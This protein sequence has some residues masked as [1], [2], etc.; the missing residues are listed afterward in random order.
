MGVPSARPD[1]VYMTAPTCPP[2]DGPCGIT[3]DASVPPVLTV[4]ADAGTS[5]FQCVSTVVSSTR[6]APGANPVPLTVT[7]VPPSIGPLVG[8]I[9]VAVATVTPCAAAG[10]GG[11]TTDTAAASRPPTRPIV[12]PTSLASRQHRGRR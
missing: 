7:A 11:A 2:L 10:I 9:P 12:R 6:V 8:E 4:T 1:G 5:R 3:N